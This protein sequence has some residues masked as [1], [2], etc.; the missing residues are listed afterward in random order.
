MF[1]LNLAEKGIFR[2]GD[3]ISNKHELIIK[4][5]LRVLNLSPLDAFRLVS[6]KDAL[7]TQLF[8]LKK[9]IRELFIKNFQTES[10]LHQ[11]LKFDAHFV[12]TLN[13]K[14]IYSFSA[15]SCCLGYKDYKLLNRCLVKNTFLC[16]IGII[17]SPACSLCGESDESLEHLF[18]SCHYTKN[19]WS[20]VIKW[21]VD[22]KVKIE[23][24]SGKDVLFGIIGC[25]ED[26]F[27]NHILLLAKQYLYPCRQNKYPHSIRV[28]HSKI[29]T[30]FLI[31]TMIAKSNK[32]LETHN[33]QWSK[34]K[35]D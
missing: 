29:N 8:Y 18:L 13:W 23:N 26:M 6:L 35:S 9:R 3:L 12:N 17:P 32:K 7:P 28:L 31:E 33:M 16:R 15:I 30:V 24:L 5:E 25:E 20:E 34:Y 22:H 4:S 11:L 10:S 2:V 1:F 19:F 21:L 27:V 14:K